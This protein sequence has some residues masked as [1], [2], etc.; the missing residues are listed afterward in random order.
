MRLSGSLITNPAPISN[1]LNAGEKKRAN[2]KARKAQKE[3]A[4]ESEDTDY[5]DDLNSNVACVRDGKF[6]D[7]I[8]RV[9]SALT[10]EKRPKIDSLR[11]WRCELEKRTAPDN[12]G[13]K[14]QATS[15]AHPNTC[16]TETVGTVLEQ[17]VRVII[18]PFSDHP[19]VKTDFLIAHA[20][21][22]HFVSWRHHKYGTYF[23]Q[24]LVEVLSKRACQEDI[25]NM[26]TRVNDLVGK[27]CAGP[28]DHQMQTPVVEYTLRKQFFFNPVE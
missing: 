2:A 3:D 18:L 21:F 23:V 12:R 24:S 28:P 25:L 22:V 13:A 16:P 1:I 26:M 15:R 8:V 9:R 5:E 27:L 19:T 11:L 17:A 6:E 20:T 4:S 7:L 10:R 14:P